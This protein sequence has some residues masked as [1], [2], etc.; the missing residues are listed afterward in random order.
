MRGCLVIVR[1]ERFS[2]TIAT[3]LHAEKDH[4][5]AIG[6]DGARLPGDLI[7]HFK[8]KVM[9]L[10]AVGMDNRCA[11]LRGEKK[12]LASVGLRGVPRRF[13]AQRKPCEGACNDAF[14]KKI[15]PVNFR[16]VG[17]TVSIHTAAY[18]KRGGIRIFSPDF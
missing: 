18:V 6:K 9:L 16:L 1:I 11:A 14:P 3:L 2:G 8:I 5:L 7:R 13:P 10:R 17:F 15:A 12:P 4:S